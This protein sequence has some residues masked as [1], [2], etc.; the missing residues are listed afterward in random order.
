[1]QIH[2]MGGASARQL[3]SRYKM[4]SCFCKSTKYYRAAL[5]T[6]IQPR[7]I[8]RLIVSD[9]LPPLVITSLLEQ[10]PDWLTGHKYPPKFRFFNSRE[11]R[12]PYQSWLPNNPHPLDWLYDSLS[13]PPVAGVW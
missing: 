12:D 8:C 9:F 11:L 4:Y 1:M 6:H 3:Q 10:A 13:S 7:L 2:V 5:G